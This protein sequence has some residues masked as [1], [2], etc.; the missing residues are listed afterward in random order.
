MENL[1]HIDTRVS[2]T[3]EFIIPD[4]YIDNINNKLTPWKGIALEGVILSRD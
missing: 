4:K 2:G 3:L 1:Q